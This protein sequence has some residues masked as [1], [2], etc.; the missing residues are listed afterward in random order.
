MPRSQLQTNKKSYDLKNLQYELPYRLCREELQI[1]TDSAYSS[2]FLH[3]SRSYQ[4][5]LFKCYQDKLKVL[6][7]YLT[8]KN[9]FLQT[10][11]DLYY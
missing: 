9:C 5:P 4:F 2:S 6:Q 1:N 10:L 7:H 8:Y 3:S 11:C